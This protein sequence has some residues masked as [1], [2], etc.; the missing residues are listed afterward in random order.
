VDSRRL[1]VGQTLNLP[2]NVQAVT[3]N[4]P[5]AGSQTIATGTTYTVK[6]GD[7]L[8]RISKNYGVTIKALQEANGI[9]GSRINVGQKLTIP[10]PSN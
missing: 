10:V 6:S 2:P 7:T 8:T 4:V 3:P 9:K 1:Q 5:V